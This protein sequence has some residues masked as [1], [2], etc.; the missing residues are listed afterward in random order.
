MVSY[1][2]KVESPEPL[3]DDFVPEY[4]PELGIRSIEIGPNRSM[5]IGRFP[6]PIEVIEQ[7][8]LVGTKAPTLFIY[9]WG[10]IEYSDIFEPDIRRR[11]EFC[12]QL[13]T[14]GDPNLV[15]AISTNFRSGAIM[16]QTKRAY[17]S[18]DHGTTR[19]AEAQ[20]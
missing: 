1:I 19:G 7:S 14:A 12:A 13:T 6:I 2:G 3:T 17:I 4:R 11:T 16:V 5:G 18:H 8:R 10:W 15:T 20:S 9:L